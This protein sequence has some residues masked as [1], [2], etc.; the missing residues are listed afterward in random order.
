MTVSVK[1]DRV[2]AARKELTE[3]LIAIAPIF[4]EVPYFMSE[5]FGLADCYLGPLLLWR[6]PVLGIELDSR[7]A[8]DIKAYMTRILSVNRLKLL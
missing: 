7:V 1:G 3:S 4:G 5:E 8:K 2:E 6:L